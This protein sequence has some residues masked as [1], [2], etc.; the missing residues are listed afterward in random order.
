MMKRHRHTLKLVAVPIGQTAKELTTS[1]VHKQLAAYGH[2]GFGCVLALP[3]PLS[4]CVAFG[5]KP[6]V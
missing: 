3:K 6:G 1:A 5:H 2:Y 4:N